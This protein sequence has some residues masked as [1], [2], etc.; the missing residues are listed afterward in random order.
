MKHRKDYSVG[1]FYL[2]L[3]NLPR[4]EWFKWENIIVLGIFPSLDRESKDLNQFLEP[5]I[6]ELK[7]LWKGVLLR[8]CLSR[9]PLTFRAAV[10]SI[11]SDVPAL[12]KSVDSRAILRCLGALD[13]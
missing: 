10:I 5:T 4:A 1:V 8:S 7:A 6:D 12:E 2:A 3:L 13:A 9:F 11:S